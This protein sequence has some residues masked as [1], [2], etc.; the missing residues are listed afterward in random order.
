MMTSTTADPI[1]LTLATLPALGADFDGGTFAGLTTRK[2]GTHHAVV[3]LPEK[4]TDLTWKKATAWA[5]EQGGELPTR[6]VA[7]LLFA[8]VKPKLSP[9]WHWTSDEYDASCAW[10]CD[11]DY[12]SQ[13]GNR[14]SYEGS[15]V[16]V[17]L[18]PLT[19]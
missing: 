9:S 15:A 17:R 16:A 7:A 4:A 11:F 1:T 3:L 12:G 14:K 2:D 18:I 13:Y 6:P 5:K 19:A 8:N 10:E